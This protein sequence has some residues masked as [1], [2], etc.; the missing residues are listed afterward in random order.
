MTW[1]QKR[2]LIWGTTYPEFSKGHYETVCTGAIDGDTGR[3]VRIYPITLRYMDEPIGKFHWIEAEV[4]RNT[5]DFRPESYKIKQDTIRKIGIIDVKHK[6]GWSERSKWVL[7]QDNVFASVKALQDAEARDH[8][9][10]GLVRPSKVVRVYARKKS[11]QEK[12]EWNEQREAALKQRDIFVDVDTKTKDLVFVP[13][14]Y[15]ICFV[16]SD[17]TCT[18]EHDLSIL[19]WGT[20]VLSRKVFAQK[21]PVMAERDVISKITEYMDP[22]KR[23]PYL[24]L[25]NTKAHSRNFMV[26]GFFHPPHD[27]RKKTGEQISLSL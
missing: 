19:D 25:G 7:T 15:R 21:G 27:K 10:L 17:P 12:D 16:C 22:T 4:E 23:D 26:V 24:F 3:L 1:G 20:Y 8:T 11:R 5:S 18:I 6:S 9:S 14:Q 2:L 13:V